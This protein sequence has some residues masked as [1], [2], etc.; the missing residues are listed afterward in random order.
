M[1]HL[2][3]PL[4]LRDVVL[5]HR[6]AMSPMCQYSAEEG[7]AGDWHFT[8]YGSRATGGV[9]LMIVEATGVLPA[10]RISPHDL[11]LW[12]D[13]QI[14]PLAR[15]AR[16]ARDQGCVPAI[17]LAHAGRKASVGAGW[18]APGTLSAEAGGW[19]P[20]GP[21]P[22]AFGDGHAVPAVLDEAG[23]RQVI[24]SFAAAARRAR[25]A[26]FEVV[27]VHAAH[28]YLL[29]QFLSPLSN[30]RTDRWGGSFDHR[31]RL[32][33]EVAAAV[34]AVWP[35]NLPVLLRLSATDW[36]EGGWNADDSV[37][38]CHQLKAIGID[39]V[40]VSTAGLVPWA[41][42]PIGPG[43]QTG[44]AARIRRETGLPTGTVGLIT[45]PAQADHIV[46]SG[47]ADL[48]LLGRELLR[49]PYWPLQA[50]QALGQPTGWPRQYLRSA[51]AGTPAR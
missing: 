21:S 31:T 15:I 46:R 42:I 3:A 34:R 29:H 14:E 25:T 40:D 48:V 33:R 49:N 2:F 5:P 11:G 35:D 26:G 37:A 16:F 1:S 4:A 51:P 22:L 23:I 47:Q 27:E 30:E 17:Q 38:L 43:Y 24:D 39:L 18:Q 9:A 6:I 10:G 7:V 28:G 36:V 32:T 13:A 44:F 8:H 50:A 41:Q 19:L 45:A 20:V 12:N